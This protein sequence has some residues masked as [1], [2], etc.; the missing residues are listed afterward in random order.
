M[1]KIAVGGGCHW[2]TEAVFQ[3]LRGVT[4]VDQGWTSSIDEPGRFAEAVL[5]DFDAKVIPLSVL[6]E[7][8]LHTHSCT[9][10]HALR[11]KYRSAVYCFGGSQMEEVREIIKV[12]QVDFDAPIITEVVRFGA[13][14]Q[15]SERYQDYYLRQP[16][17]PFCER[18]IRPKLALLR[19]DF[20][21]C[22]EDEHVR[23]A[24]ET[25]ATQG[26]PRPDP[27]GSQLRTRN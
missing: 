6:V 12:A 25:Q 24:L 5:I 7:V 13:F 10:T 22:V 16:E 9:S 11:E 14:R 19:K 2:C 17:A 21:A 15:N 4:R 18:Y 23:G 26:P 27:R 1:R 20:E 8:H 3:Q